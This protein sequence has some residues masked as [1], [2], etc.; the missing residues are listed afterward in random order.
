MLITFRPFVLLLILDMYVLSYL[1]N[2]PILRNFP[3]ILIAQLMVAYSRGR[4]EVEA[5]VRELRDSM[6][7]QS[8]CELQLRM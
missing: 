5:R 7:P 6:R 8:H 4:R 1:R 2:F 3:A